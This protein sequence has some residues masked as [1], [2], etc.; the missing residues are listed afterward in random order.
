MESEWFEFLIITL[1]IVYR[2]NWIAGKKDINHETTSKMLT[3]QNIDGTRGLQKDWRNNA[4]VN[5][6]LPHSA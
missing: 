6:M 4:M 3:F 5:Y 1:L 2:V